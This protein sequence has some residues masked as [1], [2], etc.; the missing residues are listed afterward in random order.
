MR[1]RLL[2]TELA[3]M[4]RLRILPLVALL[5]LVITGMGLYASVLSPDFD[6][7]TSAAWDALLLGLGSGPSLAAPLLL[8]LLASRLVDVEH[9]GGGW[10]LGATSGVSAGRLC[11]AKLLALGIL[12]AGATVG[13]SLLFV[14]I[15]ILAGARTPWPAGRWLTLTLCLLAVNLVLLAVHV[16]LAAR[17]ENQLVGIGVGLLGT[18]IALTASAFPSW[19]VHLTPWGYYHLSAAAGYVDAEL[20][21]VAP[22]VL[23]VAALCLVA[24]AAVTLSTRSLDSQEA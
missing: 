7:A 20:V 23:S 15:G 19:V 8:A 2:R 5:P 14:G 13:T 4:R 9:Q 21:P 22:S 24:A 12:V 17:I 3:K 10:L 1:T 6:P 18:V 11:R 16:I